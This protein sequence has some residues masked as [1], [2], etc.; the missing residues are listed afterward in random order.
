MENKKINCFGMQIEILIDKDKIKKLVASLNKNK[1]WENDLGEYYNTTSLDFGHHKENCSKLSSLKN[2][3]FAEYEWNILSK[4]W[5]DYKKYFT[6]DKTDCKQA[7]DNYEIV[8]GSLFEL[9]KKEW[10]NQKGDKQNNTDDGTYKRPFAEINRLFVGFNKDYLCPIIDDSSIKKL[11]EELR[12]GGYIAI[13]DKKVLNY[14]KTKQENGGWLIRSLIVNQVFEYQD[15]TKPW[16]CLQKLKDKRI[17][18]L[19]E[20]NYNLILT[21]APGT[22]KTYLAKQIA[23]DLIKI[24]STGK[25]EDSEQYGFVQFHPSYDYTDFV[26]GLRPKD[27]GKGNVVFERKD[28]IFK[29]FCA[30]AAIAEINQEEKKFVFIID[31]I[32]RGEISKIFG[33]LFFSVDP[34]YRGENDKKGNDNKVNTQ[35]Q[36]LIKKGEKLKGKDGNDTNDD[37]PFANGFYVPRNVFI[38]GTMNDIDRSVES[39]DFAFRRR[40]A[41]YEIPAS[42]DML[43]SMENV[44][45]K[46]IEK[47]KIRMNRL[48]RELIKEQYGLSSAYQI[49]GAYFKKYEKYYENNNKNDAK[50][51][52]MLWDYHLKGLLFEYFRGL[53]SNDIKK[54][55]DNLK[56]I[57]DES[58]KESGQTGY[59]NVDDE[60]DD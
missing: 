11:I 46:D 42:S 16:I 32:N 12:D 31:E 19:L 57:F 48:N 52:Q 34:G 1:K 20:D 9:F 59:E 37:N 23:K 29:A 5:E 24:K 2:R 41:F 39:M 3:V 8:C 44:D 18:L 49:G 53:P 22:G 33:E 25:L 17:R 13:S 51:A 10:K 28:G 43:D 4:N 54:K 56:K 21:G 45:S 58:V 6:I 35:F 50:A 14:I 7:I 15:K 30:N 38:I 26:E 40:F 36:N 60:D 27:D 55:M 47:L